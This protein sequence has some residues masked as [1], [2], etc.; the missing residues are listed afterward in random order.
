[1]KKVL[2]VE[3]N[4]E[5]AHLCAEILRD[6]FICIIAKTFKEGQYYLSNGHADIL[7]TD[8]SLPDGNGWDLLDYNIPSIVITALDI[9]ENKLLNPKVEVIRKPFKNTYFKKTMQ[10][11][12]ELN[13]K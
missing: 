12:A 2:I 13:G 8:I 7:V 4:H 9:A 11:L 1:M 3:D 6:E 10:K 5:L